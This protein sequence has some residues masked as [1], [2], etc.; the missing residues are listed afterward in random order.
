[1]SPSCACQEELGGDE[2]ALKR[3]LRE[4]SSLTTDGMELHSRRMLEGSVNTPPT[5]RRS[6][7]HA[8]SAAAAQVSSQRQQAVKQQR[9]ADIFEQCGIYR[10][11]VDDE[12]N[13]DNAW[14]ETVSLLISID[15]ATT[16]VMLAAGASSQTS[17]KTREFEWLDL[18]QK[19]DSR[20][21]EPGAQLGH[22]FPGHRKWIWC[23]R[24][25]LASGSQPNSLVSPEAAGPIK[26][27]PAV[28]SICATA[29]PSTRPV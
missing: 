20:L 9:S 18:C 12:R 24:N 17:G 21:H 16:E 26:M 5:L 27:V 15:A 14:I 4:A 19:G 11:Y 1:M 2:A 10:G 8:S 25:Y 13:T 3:V 29:A 6:W 7:N 23:V 22:F 28:C